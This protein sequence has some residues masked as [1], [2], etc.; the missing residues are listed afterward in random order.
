MTREASA[1]MQK[2]YERPDL[3]P[4]FTFAVPGYN[5]RSTEL[6]AVLGLEQLKRLDSNI[7]IRQQNFN[8]WI[9][10]LD[11]NL[12]YTDFDME[13]SS[14]FAL[15]LILNTDNLINVCRI[16]EDEKVEYRLGTAGGGNQARQPYLEKFDHMISGEL[17]NSNHIHENGLYVGNHTEL[18]HAQIV[19]LCKKLNN[20]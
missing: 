18:T 5:M 10:N 7:K 13:G 16:L 1:E 14:N 3:N 8:T 11:S 17:K 12:Y 4:L 15:P 2:K 9:S 20:V 19:D 6:N